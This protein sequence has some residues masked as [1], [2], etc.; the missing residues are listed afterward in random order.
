[1]KLLIDN[2]TFD[3]QVFGGISK[4]YSEIFNILKIT[5]K[6]SQPNV[7]TKNI[8]LLKNSNY[9]FLLSLLRLHKIPRINKIII[10]L[11]KKIIFILLKKSNFDIFIPTYYNT[12]F[13]NFIG[14]KPFIVTIH[15]MN[16]ELYPFYF[17]NDLSIISKKK[18]LIEKSKKIIAVSD[19]T[20]KDIL[21]IYPHI[22]ASKIEV[23]YHAHS[24]ESNYIKEL[25]Y[26][27]TK[28]KY[29]LFVGNRERYK[30]FEWFIKSVSE[31]V[32][33]N[34]FNIICIGGNEF[35]FYEN[36]LFKVLNIENCIFQYFVREN[37][38]SSFYYNAFA[39]VFPSEYEGFGIPILEAMACECPV[40]LP[41]TSSFPEVA[42]DAGIYFDLNSSI[43]LISNLNLLL[44]DLNSRYIFVQ[45]GKLHIKK[46]SWEKSSLQFYEL[47]N[48][49]ISV[50]D[51]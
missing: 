18:L 19:N 28:K 45:K 47:C 48:N 5:C 26:Y 46:F 1:M 22:P 25:P 7:Y 17:K 21:N 32:I 24:I 11:N 12:N 14:N 27:I 43:S 16:H 10:Y 44:L 41:R 29:I 50:R 9:L 6:I 31:W 8:Y 35:S 23:I 49:I 3:N 4:Y 20:K 34:N 37:E 36:N 39:F 40:I 51:C 42:G 13:L 15:D 38:L 2:Q 30:N 33:T